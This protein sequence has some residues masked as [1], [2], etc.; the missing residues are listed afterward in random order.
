MSIDYGSITSALRGAFAKIAKS[1]KYKG[2]SWSLDDEQAFLKSESLDDSKSLYIVAQYGEASTSLGSYVL[3]VTLTALGLRDEVATARDLMS[4][5][6][7]SYNTKN[8]G[9]YT[10]IANT[11][12]I[13]SNFNEVGNGYRSLC[14]MAILIVYNGANPIKF[15]KLVYIETKDGTETETEIPLLDFQDQTHNSLAPQTYGDSNGRT[16]SYATSQTYNFNITTYSLDNPLIRKVNS[17]KYDGASQ[18]NATF[19]FTL[20]LNNGQGFTKWAFKLANATYTH[21]IGNIDG[22]GLTFTL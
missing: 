21:S 22:V 18:E 20:R 7:T 10:I 12:S 5:F 3:S 1:E 16:R 19:T 17:V 2:L 9:E 11:S 14:S 6:A 15:G 13:A 8:A 4:D